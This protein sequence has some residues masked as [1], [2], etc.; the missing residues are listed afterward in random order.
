MVVAAVSPQLDSVGVT[1]GVQP[2]EVQPR[3]QQGTVPIVLHPLLCWPQ[4]SGGAGAGVSPSA[5]PVP[6]WVHR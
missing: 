2:P 4:V 1:P 3:E 6:G 5:T